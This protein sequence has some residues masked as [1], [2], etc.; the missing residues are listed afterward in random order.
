MARGTGPKPNKMSDRKIKL[1]RIY[2]DRPSLVDSGSDRLGMLRQSPVRYELVLDKS[3]V[4]IVDSETKEKVDPVTATKIT[5]GILATRLA[6]EKMERMRSSDYTGIP[7]VSGTDV[8]N[9]LRRQT[10]PNYINRQNVNQQNRFVPLDIRSEPLE[11][12]DAPVPLVN[13]MRKPVRRRSA[14]EDDPNFYSLGAD[15]EGYFYMGGPVKKKKKKRK[16]GHGGKMKK[17]A[18]GG[19]IRKPN[20]S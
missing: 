13:T 1:K 16:M 19:G 17:Y 7:R 18:K 12:I 15:T 8:T 6:N 11:R 4:N 14:Y 5:D 3:G 2:P 10:F 9:R 20:Y